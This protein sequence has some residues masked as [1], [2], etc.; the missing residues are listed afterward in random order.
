M[1]LLHNLQAACRYCQANARCLIRDFNVPPQDRNSIQSLPCTEVWPQL[2]CL[3]AQRCV[4]MSCKTSNRILRPTRRRFSKGDDTARPSLL[5]VRG[6]GTARL[7]ARKPIEQP[8]S[9]LPKRQDVFEESWS[10]DTPEPSQMAAAALA[11]LRACVSQPGC[12]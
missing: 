8:L 7:K 12:G 9:F 6:P 3:K 1:L 10:L 4:D 11:I 2:E 5:D